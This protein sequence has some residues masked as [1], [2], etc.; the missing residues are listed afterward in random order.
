MENQLEPQKK[1]NFFQKIRKELYLLGLNRRKAAKYNELPEYLKG[2]A[3]VANSVIDVYP[4]MAQYLSEEHIGLL[5]RKVRKW[6]DEYFETDRSEEEYF[7]FFKYLP[8]NIQTKMLENRTMCYYIKFF[9]SDAIIAKALEE[10]KKEQ[11][12]KYYQSMLLECDLQNLPI[13]LQIKL[14]LL[15]NRYLKKVSF[16]VKKKFINGTP[17]FLEYFTK[18]EKEQ[19]IKEYPKFL[20]RMPLKFKYEKQK[21]T[22]NVGQAKKNYMRSIG[23][24]VRDDAYKKVMTSEDKEYVLEMLKFFPDILRGEN[25]TG[26]SETIKKVI[27]NYF[28]IID[29]GKLIIEY[30]ESKEC[31]KNVLN[32]ILKLILNED[33][34]KVVTVEEV[35]E[36]IKKPNGEKLAE[37][38]RKTYG[39][40]SARIIRDRPQITLNEIPNL[41]IFKPDVVEKFGIGAIHANL[42][43]DMESSAILGEL[44]R[45]PKEMELYKKFERLTC[46]MFED[47]AIDL[48]NKLK[49]FFQIEE[50]VT[51]CDVGELT[52]KQQVEMKIMMQ[53]CIR[54]QQIYEGPGSQ[55]LECIPTSLE[56]LEGYSQRRNKIY[57]EAIQKSTN[58]IQIKELMSERFFGC[59]Y[60]RFSMCTY[61]RNNSVYMDRL[62]V[63][64]MC[65][66]YKLKRFVNDPITLENGN[67]TENELDALELLD[68][69]KE[70]EDETILKKIAN[71][72]SESEDIINPIMYLNLQ[73]KIPQQYA[74]EMV[75]SLLTVEK[76][77][78]MSKNGEQGIEVLEEDGF[79]VIK[80]RGAEFKAYITDTNSHR[81][82]LVGSVVTM[83][84]RGIKESWRKLE[85]GISTISGC[86]VDQDEISTAGCSK[87]FNG[88]LQIVPGKNI[89]LGFYNIKLE[90]I[91]VMGTNDIH[92]THVTRQ[93]A[94]EICRK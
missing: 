28:S 27:C 25:Y 49:V 8:I 19:L 84:E 83:L 52:P 63:S 6:N 62:S 29:N 5:I 16:E 89:F 85:N 82:M 46:N 42:S 76:A 15:D 75:S 17:I 59:V 20:E 36:Y 58:I 13:E 37:I 2:D 7:S 74:K 51:N 18:E 21:D 53:D 64:E 22:R 72:L 38:I 56:E 3:D 88:E 90:Q 11:K 10:Q 33:I 9:S 69:F 12:D 61:E 55:M 30:L 31:R 23:I 14:L 65:E 4:E 71:A 73:K 68:I 92:V 39:E 93:L 41:Y 34:I 94:P 54:S 45:N 47:T 26:V 50:L 70:I 81:S 78:E 60:E 35:L 40:K 44:A 66:I 67:F 80:L 57:D 32:E 1:L 87:W 79:N 77:I 43:F 91:I 48:E 24:I 86:L